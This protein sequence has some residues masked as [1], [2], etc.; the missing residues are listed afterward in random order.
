M[1][2]R[3]DHAAFSPLPHVRVLQACPDNLFLER[4]LPS[5]SIVRGISHAD[6]DDSIF[7]EE[8]F[9]SVLKDV[10]CGRHDVVV[11]FPPQ[12]TFCPICEAPLVRTVTVLVPCCRLKK[13]RSEERR[14]SL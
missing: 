3:S 8:V 11:L 6:G 5:G 13:M 4:F 14:F 10:G 7:S 2:A 12:T 9:A 1:D